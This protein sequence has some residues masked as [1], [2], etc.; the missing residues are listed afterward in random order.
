MPVEYTELDEGVKIQRRCVGIR[1]DLRDCMKVVEI[2]NVSLINNIYMK[3]SS[4]FASL[5]RLKFMPDVVPR[6]V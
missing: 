2:T 5:I 1:T 6:L 4:F 3:S